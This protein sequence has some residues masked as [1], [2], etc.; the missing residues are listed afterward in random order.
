MN[1][2]TNV[3]LIDD[4]VTVAMTLGAVLEL[5][6]YQV[7]I[8]HSISEMS[9]LLSTTQFDIA[10]VDLRLGDE[11]GMQAI[12][13]LRDHQPQCMSIVLT[14]YPT[15]DSMLA[16]LRLHVVDFLTKPCDL[17]QLKEAVFA[18]KKQADT[19][20]AC[21]ACFDEMKLKN[22]LI[23]SESPSLK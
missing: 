19:L 18:A 13:V 4:D 15:P 7:G 16:A 3:L 5:E 10:I 8:G 1:D 14:G 9:T 11:D 2:P 17:E 20:R 21:R 12:A 6:N 22:S 23:H